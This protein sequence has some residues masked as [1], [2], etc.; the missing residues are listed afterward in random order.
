MVQTAGL[1]PKLT[2]DDDETTNA[3]HLQKTQAPADGK[4]GKKDSGKSPAA[5][6]ASV[7]IWSRESQLAGCIQER[8]DGCERE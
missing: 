4:C 2:E 6:M 1:F 5:V 7:L 3:L 8:S